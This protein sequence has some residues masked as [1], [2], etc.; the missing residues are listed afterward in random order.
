MGLDA[1]WA[2]PDPAIRPIMVFSAGPTPVAVLHVATEGDL[3]RIYGFAVP[4]ELRGKG[5]GGSALRMITQKLYADGMRA[6]ELEVAT[7]NDHAL[8]LYRRN[9]FNLVSTLDYHALPITAPAAASSPGLFRSAQTVD[10]PTPELPVTHT[11]GADEASHR[12][13]R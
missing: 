10:L 2:M 13:R 5:H 6:V 9:G 7:E 12:N 3:G 11:N 8:M 4:S 1:T